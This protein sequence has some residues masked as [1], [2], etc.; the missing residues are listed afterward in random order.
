MVCHIHGHLPILFFFP[1]LV[2]TTLDAFKRYRIS[3]GEIPFSYGMESA[4]RDPS[5][6]CQHPL[7]PNQYVQMIYRLYLRTGDR[8]QLACFTTRPSA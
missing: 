4:M 5:Y 2:R 6:H 7:N 3:D 8:D 1:E